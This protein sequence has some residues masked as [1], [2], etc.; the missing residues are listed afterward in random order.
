M[1]ISGEREER[2]NFFGHHFFNSNDPK[3][4]FKGR[5]FPDLL[6]TRQTGF[7]RWPFN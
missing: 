3:D 1:I 4:E 2:R 7:F 5:N 6:K